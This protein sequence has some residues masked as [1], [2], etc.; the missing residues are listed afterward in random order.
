MLKKN[1]E[2]NTNIK[3][4]KEKEFVAVP[5]EWNVPEGQVTQFA[6]NMVIQIEDDIFKLSFFEMKPPINLNES[7]PPPTKIRADC[8]ASVYITPNKLSK[9][10]EIL[11]THLDKYRTIKK[12]S[13]D[14]S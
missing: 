11:Q 5:I 8:V 3:E 13:G 10:I 1:L 4:G 12:R 14:I 7:A 9:L 2:K 6:S